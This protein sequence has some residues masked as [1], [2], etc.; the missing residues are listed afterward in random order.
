MVVGGL[1]FVGVF[2]IVIVNGHWPAFLQPVKTYYSNVS[3]MLGDLALIVEIWTFLGPGGLI[4]LL[5]SR[6][7][8]A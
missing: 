8:D 6:L 3:A 5:G 4:Y 2:L 1:A 7:A